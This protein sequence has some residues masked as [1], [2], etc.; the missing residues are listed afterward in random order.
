MPSRG[1]GWYTP[2]MHIGMF[3]LVTVHVAASR[4]SLWKECFRDGLRQD[5]HTRAH[6]CSPE[7]IPDR[8]AAAIWILWRSLPCLHRDMAF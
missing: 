3:L 8:G 2:V 1:G 4:A 7:M 5:L 6:K